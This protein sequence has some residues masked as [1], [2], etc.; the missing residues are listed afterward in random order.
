VTEITGI[1][2]FSLDGNFSGGIFFSGGFLVA[3]VA[4]FPFLLHT[5]GIDESESFPVAV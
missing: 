4:S 1:D 2:G 3:R 5:V